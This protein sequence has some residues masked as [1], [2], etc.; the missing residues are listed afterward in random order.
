MT[1]RIKAISEKKEVTASNVYG[2]C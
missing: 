1:Q 2:S